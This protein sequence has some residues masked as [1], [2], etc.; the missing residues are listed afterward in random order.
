M[1]QGRVFR[2]IYLINKNSNRNNFRISI[3]QIN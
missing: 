1:P 2:H 3:T